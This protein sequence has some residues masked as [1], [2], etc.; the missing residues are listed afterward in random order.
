[1]PVLV[2]RGS[3]GCHIHAKANHCDQAAQSLRGQTGSE[4]I[5]IGLLNNMPDAA[6][7]PTELQFLEILSSAAEDRWIHLRFFSLPNVPRSERGRAHLKQY[8]DIRDLWRADL[9]GL[10][11][12]GTEPKAADLTE[13]PYWNALTKVVDWAELNTISTIWSCLAS[14]AAVLHLDG[15]RRSPLREKCFGI[16]DC[17]V[18]ADHPL[19]AGLPPTFRLPHARCNELRED[20]LTSLGYQVLT[21]SREAGVDSFFKQQQQSCF[22][23]LQGHPEYDARSLLNEYRRDIGRFLRSERTDYPRLPQRY[24]DASTAEAMLVF[25]QRAKADRCEG[26]LAEFPTTS[27]DPVFDNTWLPVA[28]GIYRNWLSYILESKTRYLSP[29]RYVA[30]LRLKSPTAS[31]VA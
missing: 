10:I 5:E 23:F 9:D 16:F 15:A 6:L 14:H 25:E 2:D 19:T 31:A 11:V 7:E 21:R 28:V 4:W 27:A 13:E 3:G 20:K 22:L 17:D 26:M 1:M 30:S 24:F 18:V 8:F 12:T 29:P